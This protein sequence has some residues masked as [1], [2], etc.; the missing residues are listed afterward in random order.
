[1]PPDLNVKY[2]IIDR[3]LDDK[4]STIGDRVCG[5]AEVIASGKPSPVDNGDR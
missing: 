5:N 1:V 4:L 2:V 3:K